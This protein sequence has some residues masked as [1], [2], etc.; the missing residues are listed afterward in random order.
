MMNGFGDKLYCLI[1]KKKTLWMEM[2][3]DGEARWADS[4][5]TRLEATYA[6]INRQYHTMAVIYKTLLVWDF[7]WEDD[8]AGTPNWLSDD[9]KK[10]E[11]IAIFIIFHDP[12]PRKYVPCE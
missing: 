8:L 7:R 10:I 3:L 1:A 11:N 6:T 12:F 2:A 5:C 9:S 4:L